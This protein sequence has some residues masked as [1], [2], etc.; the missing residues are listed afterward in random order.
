M[1]EVSELKTW[2]DSPA[3]VV[4]AVDGVSFQ[5][6]AG[7][8]L[9]V[10]GESGS[11]KSILSRS[12]MNILPHRIAIRAGGHVLFRGQDLYHLSLRDLRRL[13]GPEL[14]MIFQDPMT[15]LNPVL[16]VEAQLCEALRLH[17]P[18]S[19]QQARS[20]A[21][22]LLQEVG[23]PAPESRL[24]AYPHQLSGGMRQRVIIAIAIACDPSL[25]IADEPTTALDVTVQKQI[26][27]LLAGQQRKRHMGMILVTHDLGVVAARSDHIAV[28]YAGRIVEYAPT[29]LLFREPRHPYTRALMQAIP[30]MSHPAHTRLQVIPGRP[31]Q[32]HDLPPGCRFAPR[33]PYAQPRCLEEDPAETLEGEVH[34]YACFHPVGTKQGHEALERNRQAGRSASGI[35][36]TE[37]QMEVSE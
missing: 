9:G 30:R 34:R 25:L 33:C 15:A 24:H 16:T 21:V 26:L 18:L 2:F 12:I 22:A 36:V 37:L 3:G 28:M 31:P 19:R 11:G 20:R 7:R 35:A 29:E 14:A 5:L 8:T 1:L 6:E 13:W 27:D 23:I 17:L 10:V 4:H 32:L